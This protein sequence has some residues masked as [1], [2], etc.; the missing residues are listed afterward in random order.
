MGEFESAVE[1]F[2]SASEVKAKC[3]REFL[4]KGNAFY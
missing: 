4:N 1:S 2:K 3:A